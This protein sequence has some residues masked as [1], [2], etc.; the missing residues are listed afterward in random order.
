MAMSKL[1]TGLSFAVLLS[2]CAEYEIDKLELINPEGKEFARHLTKEYLAFAKKESREYNDFIDARHFA[3]KGEQAATGLNVLP[4]NPNEWDVAPTMLNELLDARERLTFALDK[5]GRADFVAPLAAKAQVSY[6]CW[7]Q[8]VEEKNLFTG[9]ETELLRCRDTFWATLRSL[10]A[11]ISKRSPVF[12]VHFEKDSSR[13]SEKA[14]AIIKNIYNV[15]IQLDEY[16]VAV[17]GHTDAQGGRKSNLALSQARA[18][19]VRDAL[20]ALGIPLNRIVAVGTGEVQ[21]AQD[22]SQNRRV[23]VVI[24]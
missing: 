16:T 20:H 6:D 10:E 15:A 13:L 12:S 17:T 21:G 7:V 5:G 19:V 2:G 18:A 22:S 9:R 8:E 4:E 11:E 23:D 3:V 14:M 1:L 24:R